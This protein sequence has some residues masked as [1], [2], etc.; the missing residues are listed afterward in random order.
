MW[1]RMCLAFALTALGVV[2]TA[3]SAAAGEVPY[4]D[5]GGQ[6]GCIVTQN[7]WSLGGD[8]DPLTPPFGPFNGAAVADAAPNNT[9]GNQ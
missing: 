6:L 7:P 2:G 4:S 9:C 3:S 8:G 5:S 1:R